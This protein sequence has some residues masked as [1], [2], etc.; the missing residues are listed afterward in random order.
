MISIQIPNES[1]LSRNTEIRY[2][3]R[4]M[5][6]D[7]SRLCARLEEYATHDSIEYDGKKELLLQIT[8][9][10]KKYELNF[11]HPLPLFIKDKMDDMTTRLRHFSRIINKLPVC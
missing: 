8:V 5:Y 11:L 2:G 1:E 4:M 3:Y 10:R 7:L 9:L 6:T